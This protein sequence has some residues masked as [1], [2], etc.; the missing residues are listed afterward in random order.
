MWFSPTEV[1][2][3]IARGRKS[4]DLCKKGNH[5]CKKQHFLC[6]IFCACKHSCQES[7]GKIMKKMKL[8][9]LKDNKLIFKCCNFIIQYMTVTTE[10]KDL[11]YQKF[12]YLICTVYLPKIENYLTLLNVGNCVIWAFTSILRPWSYIFSYSV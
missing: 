9:T 2:E 4:D 1:P 11:S 8:L 12:H 3:L 7:L 5:S 10:K 6:S